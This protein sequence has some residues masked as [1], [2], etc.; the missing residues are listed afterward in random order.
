MLE[1]V[2][3]AAFVAAVVAF[4]VW[5]A[6]KAGIELPPMYLA[7][8]GLV[9]ALVGYAL[10]GMVEINPELAPI[11]KMA[12]EVLIIILSALG[13]YHGGRAVKTRFM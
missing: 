6:G 11:I 10:G 3:S 5:L 12:I 8:I 4:I 9:V 13:F 2:F 7:G 1:T